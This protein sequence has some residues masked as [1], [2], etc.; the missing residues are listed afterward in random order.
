M[1][2]QYFDIN[3]RLVIQAPGTLAPASLQPWVYGDNYN[4]AV[5]LV[6][7][8][9]I[10]TIGPN[11]SLTVM[12]FQPAQTLP[13]QNLAIVSIPVVNTDPT[14]FN[15]Y[16]INVNLKTTQLANLVQATNTPAKCEFH[17]AFTPATGERFSSSADVPVTV[18]PDPSEGATGGTPVPPGYPT[19][20]NVFEQ[21]ANK[22]LANGYPGL[23]PN[24]HL[25]PNQIPIDTTL[26]VAGG[27]LTVVGGAGGGN[28][29]VG[30]IT[31]PF[32]IPAEGANTPALT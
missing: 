28:P 17:Y 32:A 3:Q 16:E 31:A 20:P 6:G 26:A 29:Y 5:Y 2:T 18:N 27:K 7:N 1:I 11:D 21:I 10:Q 9:V 12:L 15:Y 13:E 23:D 30:V 24:V 22:N 4:L 14:G 25:N 19:S 8:G